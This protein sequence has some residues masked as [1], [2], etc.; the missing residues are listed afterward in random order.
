MP[1]TQAGEPGLIDRAIAAFRSL[2]LDHKAN[3]APRDR[4][5][6]LVQEHGGQLSGYA[7]ALARATGRS[8]AKAWIVLPVAAGAIHATANPT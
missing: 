4:W 3:P 2:L 1:H 7:D 6:Q 8:V 5:D